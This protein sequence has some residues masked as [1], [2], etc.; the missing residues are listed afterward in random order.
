MKRF[1]TILA[2]AL[3]LIS[4]ISSYAQDNHIKF[5]PTG[6]EFFA[7]L[8]DAISGAQ[9]YIY[10]EYFSV[11]CDSVST[12]IL[13]L[14][15]QKA[16]EG[17][18]VYAMV[19]MQGSFHRN[20]PMTWQEIEDYRTKGLEIAVFNPANADHPFPF[21]HRKLTVVDGRT[22]FAGGMNIDDKFIHDSPTLGKTVD[23]SVRIEGPAIKQLEASFKKAWNDFSDHKKQTLF[24]LSPNDLPDTESGTTMPV[25]VIATEGIAAEPTVSD[26]YLNLLDSARKSIRM[27]N[28]YFMPSN[29]ILRAIKRAARRGVKVDILIGAN[30]DLPAI[31]KKSP[32]RITEKLARLENITTRCMEGAFVHEKAI[33]IDSEKFMVGSTNLDY[34]SRKI[35]YELSILIEN[36]ALT[37]AFDEIF[38]ERFNQ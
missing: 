24:E 2:A 19:D 13:D 30:T 15:A 27:V 3:L 22:A 23:F 28:A 11:G 25:T 34:L 9:S 32:Y 12:A 26:Y 20:N 31:L 37:A 14:L 17:V 8:A 7:E 21:D 16:S 10:F 36:A 18:C 4:G 33:S 35:N 38:D 1:S 5:L 6:E 29:K